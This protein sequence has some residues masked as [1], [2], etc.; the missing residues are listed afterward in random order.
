MKDRFDTITIDFESLFESAP[1]L[2]VALSPDLKI[3]GASDAYL[4]ATN[5]KRHKILGGDLFDACPHFATCTTEDK[6]DLELNEALHYV[7]KRKESMTLDVRKIRL[8]STRDAEEVRF[9]NMHLIPVLFEKQQLLCIILRVEDVTELEQ[10]RITAKEKTVRNTELEASEKI[11]LRNLK[12]S[13]ARFIKVFNLSPA[14]LFMMTVA[15]SRLVLANNAFEKFTGIAAD[16][17]NGKKLEDLGLLD[18]E[19]IAELK[20]QLDLEHTQDIE[21]SVKTSI[22]TTRKMLATSEIVEVD[23]M[24]CHLVAMLDITARKNH[25]IDL[26]QSNH[27]LDTILEHLPG[28]VFVK[29]AATLNYIRINKAGESLLGISQQDIIGKT[30]SDV[31]PASQAEEITAG[32]RDLLERMLPSAAVEEMIKINGVEKW[33]RTRRIPIYEDGKPVYL[34]GISEDVTEQK[35]QQEAILQLNKELEAF[36]YSVS[37]D[38]RAPLRA[39]TGFAKILDEDF[40]SVLNEEGKRQ[41]HKISENAEQMG[42]L[43]DNLL[44]FSRL[45]RKELSKRETDMGALVTRALAEIGKST[46]HKAEIKVGAM[47]QVLS[48]PDL[49][50]QV[51]INLIE[52]SIKYTSKKDKPEI[53]IGSYIEGDEAVFFVS[54]NGAG[55]DMKYYD[56]LFGVFQRLHAADEYD[57]TGVGLAIVQRI[58]AR[59]GGRVWAKGKVDQGA[60]FSFALPILKK[61]S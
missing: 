16:T 2:Y 14:P 34:V 42:I 61:K 17:I 41:L 47:Q 51:L 10:A 52:N 27:F 39:V 55:F 13:E 37:H 32:E 11:H 26:M 8:W 18:V 58:I 36:S 22:G 57:G 6:N 21:F 23:N 45:G 12:E 7:L 24:L 19:N 4:E 33:L 35:K 20:Q 50:T 5:A 59:H 1:N 30:N 15:D 43:I 28:M 49:I 46:E 60:T 54:D 31:Y 40:S 48:D 25:E 44:T 3:I 38:L 9:W 29:D 56:K 53:E